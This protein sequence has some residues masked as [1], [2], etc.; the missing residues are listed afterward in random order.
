MGEFHTIEV[1]HLN[2][3]EKQIGL[4]LLHGIDGLNGVSKGCQKCQIRRL[5]YE[6][7]QEFDS[8]RLVVD[9]DTGK[10]HFCLQFTVY[11]L[12]MISFEGDANVVDVA[13]EGLFPRVAA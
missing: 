10:G 9:D 4:L 6:G 7:L 12:Q 2:V 8:Q 5:G 3:E 13:F 11:S 1:G